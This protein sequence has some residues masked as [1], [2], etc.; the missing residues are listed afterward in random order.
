MPLTIG[1]TRVIVHPLALL[2]PLAATMLGAGREVAPLLIALILHEGAH[3][4]IAHCLGVSIPKLRVTPF[5]GAMVMDN[6]YGLSPLRLAAVAA[7]GPLA[8]LLAMMAAA[9]L[10][11]WQVA[12]P[13][14]ALAFMQTNLVLLGFNLLPALPLD[15]GRIAYALLSLK[16]KPEKALSFGIWVGRIVAAALLC[17]S[18]ASA[19]AWHS[20][21]LSFLFAA[22]FIL[23]SADDERQAISGT[24]TQA[25]LGTLRPIDK[26]VTA[27]LMAVGA[28]CPARDA[29][30]AARPDAPTLF[31]VYKGNRLSSITDDRRLVEAALEGGMGMKV[32]EVGKF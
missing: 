1:R 3:L 18:V 9:A 24:R 23:A 2:Y 11:H 4:V 31:A 26:P 10:A 12:D 8:N 13:C 20:V 32:G 16:Y 15:G 19:V 25:M 14:F 17:A 30:R 21:N 29:L 22:V 6:P 5:G 7:A 28:D 27:R